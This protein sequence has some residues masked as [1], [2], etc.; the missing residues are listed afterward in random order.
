MREVVMTENTLRRVTLRELANELGLKIEAARGRAKRNIS[1][2][3]WKEEPRNHPAAPL[4][5]LVPSADLVRP[6]REGQGDITSSSFPNAAPSHAEV[7][8]EDVR[9]SYEANLTR[10]QSLLDQRE[11]R[12][13]DLIERLL[14][15]EIDFSALRVTSSEKEAHFREKIDQLEE[16]IDQLRSRGWLDRLLKR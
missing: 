6:T 4:V 3:L 8:L 12:I 5:L 9:A 11:A 1:K 14:R 10:M 16:V 7:T 13:V 2:G 15:S